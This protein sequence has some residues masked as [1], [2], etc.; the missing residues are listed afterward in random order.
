MHWRALILWMSTVILY[1]DICK[2]RCN[3][4]NLIIILSNTEVK[5]GGAIPSLLFYTLP[6]FNKFYFQ[7]ICTF[8]L[9]CCTS[10]NDDHLVETYSE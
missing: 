6:H 10:P 4:T 2:I 8:W 7:F 5:S 3:A 9:I 1:S